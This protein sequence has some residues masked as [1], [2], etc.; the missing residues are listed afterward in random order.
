MVHRPVD[1]A[2][3]NVQEVAR[4]ARREA[5]LAGR[6]GAGLRHASRSGTR[7][8]TRWRPCST[9]WGATGDWR[10]SGHETLRPPLGPA[11]AR[12]PAGGD[13]RPTA[14]EHGLEFADDR[15]NAYPG[16]A[17]TGIR[18]EVLPPGKRR[19]QERWTRRLGRRRWP[20][21][22]RRCCAACSLEAGAGLGHPDV[23][24]APAMNVPGLSRFSA[25]LR[26]LLLHGWLEGRARPAASRASVLAVE[27]LLA[28]PGS[29]E[30][31]LG[32]GW[33]ARKEYDRRLPRA[34]LRE[35]SPGT[36]PRGRFRCPV[37]WSGGPGGSTQSGWSSFL[38]PD[39]AREAFVDA[40]AAEG[41]AHGARPAAGR[42]AAAPGR[43]GDAQAPGR[44]RRSAGAGA[45][46]SLQA[47]G[48]LWRQDR[49]GV[50]TGGRRRR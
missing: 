15:G 43:P 12:L 31:S 11:A 14:G 26:R 19:C 17:R 35:A 45:E 44:V 33:R 18:E 23:A 49:V 50:W 37:R 4:D 41:P 8:T 47:P 46:R 1:K 3:G 24:E 42:P 2:A 39:P 25:P 22:W 48:G 32:G 5:A 6:R 16:Y 7:P 21:R 40:S 20:P 10:R 36:R 27:A 28:V 38:A 13:A 29:A 34:R 30:R 9:G